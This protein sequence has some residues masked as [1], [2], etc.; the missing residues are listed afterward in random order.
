MHVSSKL[1][2]KHGC[3]I[4]EA[5]QRRHRAIN[6]LRSLELLSYKSRFYRSRTFQVCCAMSCLALVGWGDLPVVAHNW[7]WWCAQETVDPRHWK[8]KSEYR[9]TWVSVH[10]R[11]N[12][13]FGSV[14]PHHAAVL[15]WKVTI[16]AQGGFSCCVSP[17]C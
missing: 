15:A 7:R 14:Y 11:S 9:L 5:V 2:Q 6:E 10:L 12:E 4:P 8:R 16:A 17:S 3:D 1:W 13:N